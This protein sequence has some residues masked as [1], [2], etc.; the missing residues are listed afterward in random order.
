[1]QNLGSEQRLAATVGSRAA[2][3]AKSIAIQLSRSEVATMCFMARLLGK[4]N[5]AAQV[6]VVSGAA[7]ADLSAKVVGRAS[8][9][10]GRP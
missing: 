8:Q 7:G 2:Y 4:R 10:G 1:M 9:Q 6:D 3:L 5:E